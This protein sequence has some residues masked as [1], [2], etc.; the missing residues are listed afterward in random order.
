VLVCEGQNL[1]R[2]VGGDVPAFGGLADAQGRLIL[3]GQE[4]G[5]D[6]LPIGL[7]GIGF[8]VGVTER[9]EAVHHQIDRITE[10]R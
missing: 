9:S 7:S 4:F 1:L 8:A 5:Q 6:G 3:A 10:V 2:D